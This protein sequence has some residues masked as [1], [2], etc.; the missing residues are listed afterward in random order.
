MHYFDQNNSLF[1]EDTYLIVNNFLS[2]QTLFMLM[3]V[4]KTWNG[5]ST[6]AVDGS[7]LKTVSVFAETS[8]NDKTY[9]H[10]LIKNKL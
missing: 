2:F 9:T 4:L 6:Y 3:N 7:N 8:Q 10:I 1:V 5:L